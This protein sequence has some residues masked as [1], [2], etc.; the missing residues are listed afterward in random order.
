MNDSNKPPSASQSE[1][2]RPKTPPSPPPTPPPPPPPVDVVCSPS[3]NIAP[4]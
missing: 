4:K 3:P 1:P 2:N